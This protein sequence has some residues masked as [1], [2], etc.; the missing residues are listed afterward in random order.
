MKTASRIS[1]F[2]TIGRS[3]L[4]LLLAANC[5]AAMGQIP[6]TSS[7]LS[8]GNSSSSSGGASTLA[9]SEGQSSSSA[10]AP[11]AGLGAA[12]ASDNLPSSTSGSGQSSVG[13]GVV[14]SAGQIFAILQE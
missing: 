12:D 3:S 5:G 11:L 9:G 4:A 10:S 6:G 7:S 13:S 1:L 14:L 8:G 2:M